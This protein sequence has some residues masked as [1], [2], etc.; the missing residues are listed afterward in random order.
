MSRT[1]LSVRRIEFRWRKIHFRIVETEYLV[2]VV[3]SSKKRLA[4]SFASPERRR[5][6]EGN[7]WRIL[8]VKQ[9]EDEWTKRDLLGK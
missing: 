8:Q 9:D 3:V 1:A 4:S 6:K 5:T 7:A 2:I